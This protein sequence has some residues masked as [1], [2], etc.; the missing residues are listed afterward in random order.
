[1]RDPARLHHLHLS[2]LGRGRHSPERVPCGVTSFFRDPDAWEALE[3][4]VLP[5]LFRD[6][7]SGGRQV[8]TWC[9]A[10]STGEEAY[11]LALACHD[12]RMRHGL[13]RDF[14]IYATD[15]KAASPEEAK[16]GI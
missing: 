4:V 16:R 6:G 11:S 13:E 8:K 15:L 9:A 12:F 7:A 14:R 5:Q 2:Q 10:C 3:E 1:V